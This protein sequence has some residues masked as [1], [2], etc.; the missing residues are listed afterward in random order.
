[1]TWLRDNNTKLNKDSQ[2]NAENEIFIL[3]E[4]LKYQ[5]IRADKLQFD[6]DRVDELHFDECEKLHSEI[7]M[8]KNKLLRSKQ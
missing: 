3:E 7:A 6:L 4:N 2:M 5:T 1:M 8:L